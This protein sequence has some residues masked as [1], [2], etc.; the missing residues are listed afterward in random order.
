MENLSKKNS[1]LIKKKSKEFGFDFCG[2]SKAH[3]LEEEAPKLETWLKKNYQGKMNWMENYFDMRLDPRLLVPGAKSVISLLMNY[4][5]ESFQNENSKYKVSK[6]AYGKDYHLILKEKC[7]HLM[8]ELKMEIGDF[9]GRA[10]TDSAPVMDKVWAAKSGLGWIGKNSNLISKQNGSFLFIAEIILD[11]E[12]E[13]DLSTGDFCGTCTACIDSCPTQAIVAPY[14]VDGSRC[15]SYLTIELKEN[16]PTEFKKKMDGWV[17]GCDVCQDVCPWNRFSKPSKV[18]DFRLHK[19]FTD[20][21]SSRWE[22]ITD[23]IFNEVF[24]Q[25]P[26]KRTKLKGLKRNITFLQ[27]EKKDAE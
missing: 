20:W 23:E 16:I 13:P 4:Y 5:P 19:D 26:I 11:V 21:E 12:L 7:K 17:F 1:Q 24:K 10:F 25:S 6:Y 9:H 8:N 18:D 2:I 14:V 3:F 27:N 22:E 15:I